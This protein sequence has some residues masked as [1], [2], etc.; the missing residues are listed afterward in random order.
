MK[1]KIDIGL[2][3][4]TAVTMELLKLGYDVINL[5]HFKNN[6]KNADLICM[7]SDTGKSTMIQVKTGTT[8]NIL[9]GFTSED[10]GTIKDIEKKIN[11]PWI[12]VKTDKEKASEYEFYIL[13]KEEIL[14]LITTS[15]K[16]YVTQWNRRLNSNPIIGVDIAW[17]EG[18]NV[19]AS[20]SHYKIQHPE[21]KNPLN[22]I[23]TKDCW[24]KIVNILK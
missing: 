23:T 13:T 6:Y 20:P 11:G 5:N 10:D 17:L 8:K 14:E 3:G 16:W 7:N 1:K 9:V 21:Y 19:E 15:N 18:K 4:E 24:N 2:I 22:G 12:F